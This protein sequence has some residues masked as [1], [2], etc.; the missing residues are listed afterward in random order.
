[1]EGLDNLY[2]INQ[3]IEELQ[4]RVLVLMYT[5]GERCINFN[6]DA[7][8]HVGNIR[9]ELDNLLRARFHSVKGCYSP[10]TIALNQLNP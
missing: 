7:L 8:K 1:M 5:D 10:K 3:R 9:V 4:Q 6:M 2:Q